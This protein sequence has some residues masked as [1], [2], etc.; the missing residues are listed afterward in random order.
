M[1]LLLDFLWLAFEFV[2]QLLRAGVA[3]A[4]L[5]VPVPPPNWNS[6]A[7]FC[8]PWNS[9]LVPYYARSF[10]PAF[11]NLS[12]MKCVCQWQR[13]ALVGRVT[14]STGA[15]SLSIDPEEYFDMQRFLNKEVPMMSESGSVVAPDFSDDGNTT[16]CSLDSRILDF[17][18]CTDISSPRLSKA[19][20]SSPALRPTRDATFTALTAASERV[21]EILRENRRRLDTGEDSDAVRREA[22]HKRAQELSAVRRYKARSNIF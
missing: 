20:F 22:R 7:S 15:Q 21:S 10:R 11:G 9:G 19:M 2:S 5:N 13:R 12:E 3:K 8:Q 6:P 18:A 17:P 14:R 1:S 4:C 16:L